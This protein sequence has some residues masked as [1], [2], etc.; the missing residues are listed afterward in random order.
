MASLDDLRADIDDIDKQIVALLARR[1]RV[2]AD[3][4]ALKEQ[5]GAT[6]IQPDRVR[7]VLSSRRQ[8]AI[9]EG[10]DADFA[11]HIFRT[12]LAETHRIEVADAHPVPA[13]SKSAG[14]INRS[15]L[16]TVACRIDHVVVAV[17][18]IDAARHFFADMGFRIQA[19]DDSNVV[20][21]EAG[22]VAVVLVGPGND[23][24]I[25]KYLSEHGSGVQHIAIEVLNAGFTRDALDSAGV[26]RLTDVI[27]DNDGHEQVFTVM[28]PASGVQL[29]FISRVGHR[30]PMTG[31]NARA[32]FRALA[33]G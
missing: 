2:C 30:V 10:V 13:P 5:T 33:D 4:A 9:D 8:W 32:L 21:A 19:T 23:P 15:E 25:A 29:G 7:R 22:G 28:D 18:D 14:E 3:V 17:A 12:L 6:V 1:L 31:D 16:D 20:T 11:E 26:P 27:V 24:T